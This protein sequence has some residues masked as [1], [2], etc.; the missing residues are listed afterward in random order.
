MG[1]ALPGSPA[2]S[3]PPSNG[4]LPGLPSSPRAI[5]GTIVPRAKTLSRGSN[6][7]EGGLAPGTRVLPASAAH[8]ARRSISAP[9]S[10]AA[11]HPNGHPEAA[12]PSGQGADS[13]LNQPQRSTA[14][15]LEPQR[16]GHG[17]LLQEHTR[18]G[19]ASILETQRSG[20]SALLQEH[21]RSGTASILEPQRSGHSGLLLEHARSGS[22]GGGEHPRREHTPLDSQ[23]SGGSG[24]LVSGRRT[25][26]PSGFAVPTLDAVRSS[27]PPHS[28]ESLMN[29]PKRETPQS[30]S[31][32]HRTAMY[33]RLAAAGS[34]RSPST[35]TSHAADWGNQLK[36]RVLALDGVPSGDLAAPSSGGSH[37]STG[38]NSAGASGTGQGQGT[39][40]GTPKVGSNSSTGTNSAG[41][42]GTGQGQGTGTGTPKVGSNSSTGVSS[43]GASGTGQGQGTGTGTPKVGSNSS[44]GVSSAG[45]GGT[46]QGQGAG[47]G[48]GAPKLGF[49]PSLRH[50]QPTPSPEG[51]RYSSPMPGPR[52]HT[53]SEVDSTRTMGRGAQ[54]PGSGTRYT[55]VQALVDA[56]RSKDDAVLAKTI[57][58]LSGGG[59]E[60]VGL[61]D[62]HPVAGRTALHEAVMLNNTAMVRLLLRAGS[63]P[64]VA[65]DTMGPPL[66]HAA[67]WG[68]AEML[69]LLL[70]AK[71]DILAKDVAGFTAL[72]YACSAWGE[73]EM[74]SVLLEAKV[75]TL[76][77]DAA[78]FTAL[79]YACLGGHT[80]AGRVLLSHGGDLG[81]LNNNGDAPLDLARPDV[82]R[83]L[84]SVGSINGVRQHHRSPSSAGGGAG[85]A[86]PSSSG[87]ASEGGGAP[88][89]NNSLGRPPP[90]RPP[91][92]GTKLP[93]PPS[94]RDAPG[95]QRRTS[96]SRPAPKPSSKSNASIR[97]VDERDRD[98]EGASPVDE[99]PPRTGSPSLPN[100]TLESDAVDKTSPQ[101][102]PKLELPSTIR[103]R[104]S[105][106]ATLGD[107]IH[108][109]EQED[110]A[111]AMRASQQHGLGPLLPASAQQFNP[112]ADNPEMVAVG[113]EKPHAKATLTLTP[114]PKADASTPKIQFG[115]SIHPGEAPSPSPSQNHK[116]VSPSSG[117]AA[118]N[119]PGEDPP[120]SLG[121][122]FS[123]G[124]K[125]GG[126]GG[127][128]LPS[129]NSGSINELVPEPEI[130]DRPYRSP[131]Q[132]I[133]GGGPPAH[134]SGIRFG[135]RTPPGAEESTSP[136][137]HST[138]IRFGVGPPPRSEENTSSTSPPVYSAGIRFG[139]RME[140]D[141]TTDAPIQR[142]WQ[143]TGTSDPARISQAASALAAQIGTNKS[144][145]MLLQ[146][147]QMSFSQ[148]GP[149]DRRLT[150]DARGAVGRRIIWKDA[151]AGAYLQVRLHGKLQRQ[152]PDMEFYTAIRYV[153]AHGHPL[154]THAFKDLQ[155]V[156]P[157]SELA[158]PASTSGISKAGSVSPWVEQGPPMCCLEHALKRNRLVRSGLDPAA[159]E[160]MSARLYGTPYRTSK[161]S[162]TSRLYGRQYLQ[163]TDEHPKQ[164]PPNTFIVAQPAQLP[165]ASTVDRNAASTSASTSA[166][167]LAEASASRR[168]AKTA[169]SWCG[170][171]GRQGEPGRVHRGQPAGEVDLEADAL[172]MGGRDLMEMILQSFV[173]NPEMMADPA[174]YHRDELMLVPEDGFE[175][176]AED[177]PYAPENGT[178]D[179]QI[180]ASDAGAEGSGAEGSGREGKPGQAKGGYE[181]DP[182]LSTVG[183][184]S[185]QVGDE[186][187]ACEHR[188]A[189][190]FFNPQVDKVLFVV[191]REP[192]KHFW[193]TAFD[194]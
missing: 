130:P 167:S 81:A 156:I 104:L 177:G 1:G 172:G 13:W 187:E 21:T 164:L 155:A 17:G 136:P 148:V 185:L 100:S 25:L 112:A 35:P 186:R 129:S 121:L 57:E 23:W 66:L 86:P 58:E 160:A 9:D 91:K 32:I 84:S 4:A 123:V 193:V 26:A 61:N 2:R 142:L 28:S 80:E 59:S 118:P 169:W 40:T 50:P 109:F 63:N 36:P 7:K 85:G 74:L 126:F 14:S 5:A 98:A 125:D 124:S 95:H 90:S 180:D 165:A 76:A 106:G 179:M 138:G 78:G 46:G 77:K 64:N 153:S 52:G 33:H 182:P 117:R 111:I 20:H 192:V 72:H 19:T 168:E 10:Q 173:H 149:F 190:P 102:P 114:S 127:L 68:E 115:L 113:K 107:I 79:H 157:A 144:T 176:E 189:S 83:A 105:K 135:V 30:I 34:P 152:F 166:A 75:D 71:A 29:S 92:S 51:S 161:S 140:N 99:V 69:S 87:G 56:V 137:A 43:A 181:S 174:I 48:T 54:R 73:A 162:G 131:R 175:V 191:V 96:D 39:G 184:G 22:L 15:I 159:E 97:D 24:L 11:A 139:V 141:S 47:T 8:F 27:S 44:T 120:P 55:A 133:D 82:Q 42:S 65:H 6:N 31:N 194:M 18:S 108:S 110:A 3:R 41:A 122:K 143:M 158:W 132:S 163:M 60:L 154:S 12:N 116:G 38:T 171:R 119:P 178:T 103:Q 88:S 45:A 128:P 94:G 37:S 67:A 183:Q 146:R 188:A 151:P 49:R 170:A 93:K 16:S 134:S 70:E 53:V 89:L 150:V 101:R 147:A 62:R 145:D